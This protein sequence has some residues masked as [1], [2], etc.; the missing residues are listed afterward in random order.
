MENPEQSIPQLRWSGRTDVGRFRK[1]NEDAF[2]ALNFDHQEVRYLGKDGSGSLEFADFVFAV[3][4]GMGGAKAGEVASK[5][6]VEKITRLLPASFKLGA[7]RLDAGFSDVLAE[8]FSATHASLIELSRH[9]EEC[10]GM[11]ATLSLA[12][13]MPGWM[14]FGHVGDSRI[15]SLPKNGD[16]IQI[17]HDHS[18]VGHLRRLGK[19]N[20]REARTH[21]QR[22]VIDQ[23]LG[24]KT[25]FLDPQFG[26]VDYQTGDRFLLCSDG[27]CD[28]LWDRRI[29]EM[30]RGE[31]DAEQLV[32]YA[33]SES[34][35]DNTTALLIEVQ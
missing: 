26:R 17:T 6:A 2:L 19:I 32:R 16:M 30:A 33:V 22:N 18:R 21:P 29:D 1:N 3:S 11:G 10:R 8:V 12:W 25:Q 35:R 27:L 4:D 28:G 7:S 20:E 23:V 5:I 9:Y 15:Y 31:F 13:F 34:G 24:G 14:A